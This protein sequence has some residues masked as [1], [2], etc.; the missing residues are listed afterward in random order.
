MRVLVVEDDPGIAAGLL[1]TLKAAG[2]NVWMITGDK[3]ETAVN[4][5]V[6][7]AP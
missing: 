1:A 6:A 3:Q 4:V 5:G 2:V 7:C